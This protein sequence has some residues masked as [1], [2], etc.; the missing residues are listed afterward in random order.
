MLQLK[1]KEVL[2]AR[3]LERSAL[4]HSG[5]IVEGVEHGADNNEGKVGLM[6]AKRWSYIRNKQPKGI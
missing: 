1:P 3:C 6:V 2:W 5:N 4:L